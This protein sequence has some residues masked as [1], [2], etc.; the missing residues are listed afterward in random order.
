MKNFPQAA[1]VYNEVFHGTET[2]A[3]M[4]AGNGMQTIGYDANGEASD[5]MLGELGIIS[6]SPELGV[7]DRRS[8]TFFIK[9]PMILKSV[10]IENERWIF[11]TFRLLQSHID[12]KVMN[13]TYRLDQNGDLIQ[14]PSSATVDAI[15][16]VKNGGLRSLDSPL[17]IDL[18]LNQDIVS[19][20]FSVK[21]NLIDY[22][23]VNQGLEK[24]EEIS[25]VIP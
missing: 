21:S 15:V 25:L 7:K 22:D 11:N 17:K 19:G 6:F 14:D 18:K 16:R 9:E 12:I 2:P 24:F 3:G 8:E 1:F 20:L 4:L 23:S 13:A 5:W 10:M